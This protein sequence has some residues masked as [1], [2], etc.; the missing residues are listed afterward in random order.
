MDEPISLSLLEHFGN[1]VD[2]IKVL[3]MYE[4]D[5]D[6]LTYHVSPSIVKNLHRSHKRLIKMLIGFA[7]YSYNNGKPIFED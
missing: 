1:E 7:E 2:M 3:S 6:N 5:I 4:E